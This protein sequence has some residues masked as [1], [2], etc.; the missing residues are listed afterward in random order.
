MT[1]ANFHHGY[2]RTGTAAPGDHVVAE[3]QESDA[4]YDVVPYNPLGSLSL[5]QQRAR[6][7][8]F[9]VCLESFRWSFP[10]LRR[11]MQFREH[12]LLALEKYK[13]LVLVGETGCG[14]TTQ[15]PQYLHEAGW[16][17]GLAVL[18][19][20]VLRLLRTPSHLI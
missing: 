10:F 11:L 19:I 15:I 5:S 6:L 16:T 8:V 2:V 20:Q 9:K 1:D 4:N 7:P 12:I 13:T 17:A 14:K 3:K 18:K